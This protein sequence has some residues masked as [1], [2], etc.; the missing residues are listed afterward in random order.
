MKLSFVI[1]AFNEEKYLADCLRCIDAAVAA[2]AQT[3]SFSTETIVVDNNSSDDTAGIATQ[4]GATVVFEPVN[5]ISRARNTGARAATGDW[6]TFIDADSHLSAELLA[7]VL[8]LIEGGAHIGCGSLLVMPDMPQPWR[9]TIDIWSWISRML[10][11]AAGSFVVCRADVFAAI[12]GF[13]EEVYVTEEINFSRKA[14]R[15]A[16]Q[17]DKAFVVLRDHP[18]VTSA[19]KAELYSQRELL[20]QT[21]RLMLSPRKA[22]RDKD[23]LDVWYN[24]RR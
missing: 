10:N 12:G 5:Q 8:V 24:D 20:M 18:L 13:S 17:H 21:L 23:Q 19:R 2:C 22:P 14:K 6:L 4:A 15:Y 3:H 1:P 9:F 16:R 11:W 7:D